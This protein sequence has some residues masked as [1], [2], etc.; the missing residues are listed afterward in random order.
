MKNQDNKENKQRFAGTVLWFNDKLGYG[1]IECP[2]L[3]RNVFVH[4][5]RLETE[6]KFKTLSSGQIVNFSITETV[7]GIMAVNVKEAKIIPI[8]AKVVG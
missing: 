8:V 1:F 7:K 6:D 4:Y 5:N 3:Q 2:N